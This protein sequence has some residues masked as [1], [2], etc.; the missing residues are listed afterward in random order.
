M[1]KMLVYHLSDLHIRKNERHEEYEKVFNNT[2]KKIKKGNIIVIT[3]DVFHDKCHLTP[4]SLILF[5]DFML[6]LSEL[7]EIIIIDGN[8]DVNINNNEKKSNI[9]ASLKSLKSVNKINYLNKNNKIVKIDNINFILTLMNEKVEKFAREKNE[10]YV[11]LYHGT[12]NG[13]KTEEYEMN[14]EKNLNVKD[15]KEYDIT[16]LGDI[17]KHQF[18]N[19]EKTIGYA[20][21]LIQQ[22]YGEEIDNHG[23]IVWNMKTLKGDFVKIE[24]EVCYV[25][26][27]LTKDG[28]KI[29][30]LKNKKKLHVEMNYEKE[31]IN[32]C[33]N[34]ILKLKDD[35][36]I[37]SYY[38]NEI[39][40]KEIKKENNEILEKNIIEV[41][42]EFSKTKKLEIDEDIIIVLKEYI[43]E[44]NLNN[45]NIKLKNIKFSNLFSYGENNEINMRN[46]KGLIS[47]NG[48][49]GSGKSSIIDI[50]LFI[51]FDKF[52]KG[53]SKEALNMNK[54]NGQGIL[55]ME[56]NGCHYKIIRKI[57]TR[58]KST[59]IYVEKNGENI[60][61]VNKIKTDALIK[62]IVGSYE[63]F[64][65]TNILLQNELDI[66]SMNDGDKM[67]LLFE[68]LNINKYEEIKKMMDKK[69]NS[70][71]RKMNEYE[72]EIEKF[73][74]SIKEKNN[75]IKNINEN[76]KEM[77]KINKKLKNVIHNK[78]KIEY[79]ME[80]MNI[81]KENLES[82]KEKLE[83]IKTQEYD[84]KEFENKIEKLK[85]EINELEFKKSKNNC[86]SFS[87]EKLNK[88]KKEL[89]LKTKK[90]EK[91]K[92]QEFEGLT[93][94]N[95][96]DKYEKN[97]KSK[98]K[99]ITKQKKYIENLMK[100][101]KLLSKELEISKNKKIIDTYQT[102]L[103]ELCFDEKCKNCN[104][105]KIKLE[106][107]ENHDLDKIRKMKII[108]DELKELNLEKEQSNFKKMEEEYENMDRVCDNEIKELKME[109]K[110]FENNKK[111]KLLNL[112]EEIIEL[113]K[114]IEKYKSMKNDIEIEKNI[115]QKENKIMEYT[116]II[117]ENNN[118]KE[119]EKKIK[120][121][122]IYKENESLLKKMKNEEDELE[123]EIEMK[124]KLEKKLNNEYGEITKTE[125]IM[126]E[127][128]KLKENDNK[129]Y[130]KVIK[131]IDLYEKNNF[132]GYIM[133]SYIERLEI[134]INNVL[135]TIVDYKVKIVQDMNE[136]KIY[137]IENDN[138]INIRLLSGNEKFLI[139]IAVKA[140]LNNISIKYKTNFFIIDEGFGSCDEK[141]LKRVNNLLDLLNKEFEMCLVISHLNVIKSERD[142]I[143]VKKN[144]NGLSYIE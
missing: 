137:K 18:L 138:D 114:E 125:E 17:H 102:Q 67:K 82:L 10:I 16:M 84:I 89:E 28:F 37:L 73:S 118:Q 122:E 20:S 58:K 128:I 136:L 88:N 5:K 24:N 52:S 123:N 110:E 86:G 143:N 42:K 9:E 11:S 55:E 38:Y 43:K 130:L 70:L 87:E 119:L 27:Y 39:K 92:I 100:K 7:C 121:L 113:Q 144:N 34:E 31:F 61:D 23:M 139:N 69:K 13:C 30:K 44:E 129:E 112:N 12:L 2:I 60:S 126:N 47:I 103:N 107:M 4:E 85:K 83:K 66:S 105:N 97:K 72:K 45:K 76:E 99:E 29:P 93:E 75:V 77:K 3:G 106:K 140:S 104:K 53:K 59:I 96:K 21:S 64:I 98:E 51:L 109:I 120:N 132:V 81:N 41:Y 124:K 74:I 90:Y 26:C 25:K 49:N 135:M 36:K 35:Y 95:I 19:K 80:K 50:I 46:K 133:N 62:E 15:F 111:E 116:K 134:L 117:E 40:S 32:N 108:K 79:D 56:V 127:K 8:H 78:C 71:K 33:E 22:N 91:L 94:E 142:M 68:L 115:K 54:S 131:V 63:E 6:K 57:E 1:S 141:R 101:D 14:D 65:T 48:D